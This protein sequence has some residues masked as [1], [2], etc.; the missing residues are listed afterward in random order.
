MIGELGERST[1]DDHRRTCAF[2]VGGTET[3]ETILNNRWGK[4]ISAPF[5]RGIPD[6]FGVEVAAKSKPGAGS[7]GVDRYDEIRTMRLSRI[8]RCFRQSKEGDGLLHHRRRGGF[9][10]GEIRA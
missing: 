4:G 5:R 10:A 2:H 6:R 3:V 8:N 9:V 7:S 1:G